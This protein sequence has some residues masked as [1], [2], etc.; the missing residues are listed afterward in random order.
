MKCGASLGFSFAPAMLSMLLRG[1][2]GVTVPPGLD[3]LDSNFRCGTD[4][5]A[6]AVLSVRSGVFP[7]VVDLSPMSDYMSS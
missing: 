3:D 7:G 2:F 5:F 4:S 1:S 6:F